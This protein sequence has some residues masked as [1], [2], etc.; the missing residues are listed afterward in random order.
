MTD[1]IASN[2]LFVVIRAVF[3]IL[4]IFILFIPSF[5]VSLIVSIDLSFFFDEIYHSLSTLTIF[6]VREILKQ[7]SEK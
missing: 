2:A 5:V 4:L 1:T 6:F 3:I 7:T